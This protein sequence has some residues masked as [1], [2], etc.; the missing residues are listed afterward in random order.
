[1]LA[2]VARI[3]AVMAR[4]VAAMAR[5]LAPMPRMLAA[6]PRCGGDPQKRPHTHRKPLRQSKSAE[7]RLNTDRRRAFA[8]FVRVALYLSKR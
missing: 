8:N 3:V 2:A 4:M 6:M 7:H 5:M 1:M